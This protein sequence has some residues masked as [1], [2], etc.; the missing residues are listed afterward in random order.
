M[1]YDLLWGSDLA[2]VSPLRRRLIRSARLV[3]AVVRDFADGQLTLRAM[4]LVYTTL[5]SLV[6]LLALSFSVLKGFGVHNQ[7]RPALL[8]FLAPLGD[9]GVQITEQT[10]GFIDNIRVGVL[11][12]V[13]LGLL[14]YTVTALLQKIE[15]SFNYV[16]RVKRL[17]PL[18]Q[19]F[20][21]YLSVL[22]IG[23]VLVFSA[24]GI[25]ASLIEQCRGAG[26]AR[27]RAAR[28]RG[29]VRRTAAAV[30]A[31]DRGVRP[32]SISYAEHPGAVRFGRG[33]CPGGGCAV[34]DP[35][36]G[37]RQLRERIDPVHRHLCRLRDRGGVDDLAVPEL[38]DRADRCQPGLLPSVP[39]PAGLA[40]ARGGPERPGQGEAGAA[41]GGAD[42][43]ALLPRWAA[44]DRRGPGRAVGAA[45]EFGRDGA[46][47]AGRARHSGRDR[48]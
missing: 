37:V 20:S 33:R 17:R 13:G 29:R 10:I 28:H 26:A 15:L 38:A 1:V 23:P 12:A 25:T 8:A 36:L 42:R 19:R 16:W 22:T 41:A 45:G 4:S 7:V 3:H 39:R 24:I 43:P 9:K 18:A 47:A 34:A 30:S 5:L 11:G 35:R 27:D 44:M 21:Q 46:A 6:P 40:A 2:A 31:G 32:R 14:I 48:R